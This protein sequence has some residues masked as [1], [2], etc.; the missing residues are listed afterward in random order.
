MIEKND[1]WIERPVARQRRVR[2][3]HPPQPNHRKGGLLETSP[4]VTCMLDAYATSL[5][6]VMSVDQAMFD[7]TGTTIVTSGDRSGRTL[8]SQYNIADHTVLWTGPDSVDRIKLLESTSTS[9]TH[10]EFLAWA[11][12]AGAK[13]HGIGHDHVLDAGAPPP[14][15]DPSLEY[16]S[17]TLPETIDRVRQLF[18]TASAAELGEADFELDA[19]DPILTGWNA[20]QQLVALGGARPWE[21][22]PG[23]HDIGVLV[24]PSHR[25]KGLGR[26]VV[27]G[28]A[29]GVLRKNGKPLYRCAIDNQGSERLAMGLGFR[30][31]CSIQAVD[32]PASA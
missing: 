18:S 19:L 4:R 3:K 13:S 8:V 23:F 7:G 11:T 31:A 2:R 25:K 29:A 1:V 27:A 32:W 30:V 28:V 20:G 22:R 6:Q 10:G 21:D 16:L 17:G 9:L 26:Q 15:V 14:V 5:A 24:S 12:T